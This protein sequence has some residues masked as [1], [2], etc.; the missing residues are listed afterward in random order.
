[1]LG[2][3]RSLRLQTPPQTGSGIGSSRKVVKEELMVRLCIT[4]AYGMMYILGSDL[5][6]SYCT[7]ILTFGADTPWL[8]LCVKTLISRRNACLA[9]SW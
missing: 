2:V 5:N 1:M 3:S 4:R 8:V 9:M 7:L 6:I